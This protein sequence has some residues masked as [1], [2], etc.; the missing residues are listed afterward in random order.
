MDASSEPRNNQRTSG[1]FEA[2]MA[3]R[4]LARERMLLAGEL[5]DLFGFFALQIGA[6]G[7]GADPLRSAR[8]QERVLV[9]SHAVPGVPVQVRAGPGHLP[10][11]SES[12]DGILLPHT[13]ERSENPHHLL[14]EC[15]R[16]LVPEGKLLI[17]GFNPYSLWGLRRLLQRGRFPVGTRRM[18]GRRRLEDWL[19][20]LDL[21][22]ESVTPYAFRPPW[23]GARWQTRLRWMERRGPGL[24]PV[25]AGAYL[26]RCTKRVIAPRMVKPA[27]RRAREL[28]DAGPEAVANRRLHRR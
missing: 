10:F 14:R 6:W 17:L 11:A 1:W 3:R 24:W 16:V 20:L 12:V 18:L 26:V 9:T 13:L 5:G 25:L 15:Q 27:W 2:P 23:G 28:V 22:V 4:L 7:A 8:T 19:E 21:D